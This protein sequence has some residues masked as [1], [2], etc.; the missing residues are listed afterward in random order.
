MQFGRLTWG[1][2]AGS[3]ALTA[4]FAVQAIA[5]RIFGFVVGRRVLSVTFLGVGGAVLWFADHFELM[6]SAYAEP[7]LGLQDQAADPTPAS[8]NGGADSSAPR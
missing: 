8:R 1:I 5:D 3:L 6:R 2:L 4:A 7:I